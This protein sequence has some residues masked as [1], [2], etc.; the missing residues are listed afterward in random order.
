MYHTDNY[1]YNVM[2][3]NCSV[4]AFK[5]LQT[6]SVSFVLRGCTLFALWVGLFDLRL[7]S[8]DCI[9]LE[10]IGMMAKKIKIRP[11]LKVTN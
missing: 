8:L 3:M 2:M 10:L 1:N 11:G 9:R 4:R 7:A 6:C 5:I